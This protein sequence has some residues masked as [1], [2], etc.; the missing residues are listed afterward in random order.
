MPHQV[1]NAGGEYFGFT[2]AGARYYHQ[3]PV[4]M[5]YGLLLPFIQFV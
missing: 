4:N 1:G 5:H 2:G 3:R